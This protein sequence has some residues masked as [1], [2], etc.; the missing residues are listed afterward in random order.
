MLSKY[1]PPLNQ[2]DSSYFNG[3]NWFLPCSLCKKNKLYDNWI[4]F[5]R[6]RLRAACPCISCASKIK[7]SKP[8]VKNKCQ[9]SFRKNIENS[10]KSIIETHPKLLE[11]WDYSKNTEN[12]NQYTYGSKILINWICKNCNSNF[13]KC[14]KEKVNKGCGFCHGDLV[15]ETNSFAAKYPK[16]LI[17]IHQNDLEKANTTYYKSA[18]LIR[19][20]C[21]RCTVERSLPMKKLH[22]NKK[23]RNC[24]KNRKQKGILIPPWKRIKTNKIDKQNPS[25]FDGINWFLICAYCGIKII[26]TKWEVFWRFRSALSQYLFGCIKCKEPRKQ[27]K[28]TDYLDVYDDIVKIKINKAYVRPDA[29][30]G[31]VIYEFN[32]D[33]WHGNPEIYDLF[34]INKVNKKQFGILYLKLLMRELIIINAGYKLIPIWEKNYDKIIKNYK[35]EEMRKRIFNYLA[36]TKPKEAIELEIDELNKKMSIK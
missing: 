6:M 22:Y 23:C 3:K 32:G 20:T 14:I 1:R 21:P 15:N 28:W 34:K 19:Y 9:K 7:Q 13:I 26:Y 18:E 16:L 8:E 33:F 24:T 31:N 2:K 11:E 36:S 35:N 27:K 25:Y 10:G 30:K 5:R 29:I 17:N 4:T 12:P